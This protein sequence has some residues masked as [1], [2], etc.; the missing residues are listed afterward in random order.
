M[1]DS[2]SSYTVVSSCYRIFSFELNLRSI[3][4]KTLSSQKIATSLA[5]EQKFH[6]QKLKRVR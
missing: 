6:L 5:T 3:E 2:K 1:E 4:K